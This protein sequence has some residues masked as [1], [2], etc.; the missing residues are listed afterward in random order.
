MTDDDVYQLMKNDVRRV[1]RQAF[2][3]YGIDPNDVAQEAW[4][5]IITAAR[6]QAGNLE[7]P[8]TY[9]FRCILTA[10]GKVVRFS[11]Q[12]SNN[13]EVKDDTAEADCAVGDPIFRK[14][15]SVALGG[16]SADRLEVLRRFYG[17]GDTMLEIASDMGRSRQSVHQAH[18]L[19]I[20]RI[21]KNLSIEM[22]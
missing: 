5:L 22:E 6:K 9:L 15:G 14:N 2:Y 11:R 4:I 20:N 19:A 13:V 18:T 16:V 21:R 7:Y 8:R 10:I 17:K 3:K 12:S 1:S